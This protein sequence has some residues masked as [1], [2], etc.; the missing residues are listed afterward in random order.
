MARKVLDIGKVFCVKGGIGVSPIASSY[1]KS[2]SDEWQ[3]AS[4]LAEVIPALGRILVFSY[5]GVMHGK[6]VGMLVSRL[7]FPFT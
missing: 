6:I 5:D 3:L 4:S 1:S 7:S 2:D